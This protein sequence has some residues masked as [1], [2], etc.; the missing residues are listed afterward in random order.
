[1][2]KIRALAL[3]LAIIIAPGAPEGPAFAQEREAKGDLV[4]IV[5][6]ANPVNQLSAGELEKMFLGKRGFWEWGKPIK[7]IDLI[8]EN[9]HEDKSARAIFSAGY[10]G[11]SLPSLKS[12]WIRA[13]FS[14]RGQPPLVFGKGGDVVRYI[15]ENV[16][17]IGYIRKK[18]FV[19]EKVKRI[20]VITELSP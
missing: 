19:Q 9:V 11:K 16:G 1:M 6:I 17:A 18:D 20:E 5:N 3:V 14:G 4:V 10:L 12:Y 2:S 7:T 15:S 13:I 8:E